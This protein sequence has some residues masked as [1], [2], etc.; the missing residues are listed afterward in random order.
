MD[1]V[2]FRALSADQTDRADALGSPCTASAYLLV[3]QIAAETGS[4]NSI[5][6]MVTLCGSNTCTDYPS[7]SLVRKKPCSL[8]KGVIDRVCRPQPLDREL[9]GWIGC[10]TTDSR[11]HCEQRIG[12]THQYSPERGES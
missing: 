5:L 12:I 11:Y 9:S 3:D 8:R 7:D 4:A 2:E 10:T 6:Q 1:G